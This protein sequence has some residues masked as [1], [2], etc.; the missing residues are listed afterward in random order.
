MMEKDLTGPGTLNVSKDLHVSLRM[1]EYLTGKLKTIKLHEEMYSV[2]L[3]CFMWCYFHCCSK[4]GNNFSVL[5]QFLINYSPC[6]KS[7]QLWRW[8]HF[9]I[10]SYLISVLNLSHYILEKKNVI[11]A[12]VFCPQQLRE[13]SEIYTERKR[14]NIGGHQRNIQRKGEKRCSEFVQKSPKF[15]VKL[16]LAMFTFNC[17]LFSKFYL[18]KSFSTRLHNDIRNF[19]FNHS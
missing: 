19:S 18:I 12:D 14:R 15:N 6:E 5:S 13:E 2:L 11:N 7:E 17:A 4:P 9:M 16:Q 10:C 3:F 8:S 1:F